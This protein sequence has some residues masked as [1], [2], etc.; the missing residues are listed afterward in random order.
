MPRRRRQAPKG[1]TLHVTN[2]GVER[3]TI[4]RE[5]ADYRDF[6]ALLKRGRE[7]FPVSLFAF[8][9]M[10]NHFHAIIRPDHHGA[11][12]AYLHWV[13][14][15]YSRHFRAC[16]QTT[17]YGHVFQQRCWTGVIEDEVHFL[18]V[19][20][21][22]ESNPVAANLVELAESW[23]WGSAQA[24]ASDDSGLLDP[25]PVR[26]PPNWTDLLNRAPDPEDPD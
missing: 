26:L 7:R 21:Y 25:L 6:V 11:L 9:L 16:T 13:L 18:N 10:P 3:R 14:G 2:R 12:S 19:L 22:V 8:C 15:C 24:R 23:P 17:G 4:F 20:R 5:A 1:W